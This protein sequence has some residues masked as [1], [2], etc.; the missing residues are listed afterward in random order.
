M[1][2]LL[3][4]AF[5]PNVQYMSKFL[6]GKVVI[7]K[8]ETYPKQTYRNRCNILSAN[9][10]LPLSVPVQK[11]YHTL[12]KD[13][14]IDYSEMWQRNHLI[15]LK[16]AYKNSAFYDYY[17]YKFERFFE[18][19]ETFLIDLNE[20]V[21]QTLFAVLKI[22]A[23]YSY[24]TDYIFDSTGYTDFRESISP[25]PSKNRLDEAFVPKPYTQVFCDRFDFVPNLSILDLIF[26]VGPESKD[27]LKLCVQ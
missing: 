13:I 24:T 22:D 25:K 11:N 12:T 3:S 14:R 17:F 16:S 9:G 8:Y 6:A 7:E 20:N 19:R 5:F 23:D 26:N 27:Y 18:K 2:A 15:A 21:L 10:V 1:T 4:T